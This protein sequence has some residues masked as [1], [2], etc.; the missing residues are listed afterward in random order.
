MALF[1]ERTNRN[2]APMLRILFGRNGEMLNFPTSAGDP[3]NEDRPKRRNLPAVAD[4]DALCFNR[5]FD[6][7]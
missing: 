7:L 3:L 4:S 2:V 6:I 5:L 1:C